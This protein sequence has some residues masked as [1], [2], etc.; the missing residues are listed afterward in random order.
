MAWR[1]GKNVIKADTV[2]VLKLQPTQTV[3]CMVIVPLYRSMHLSFEKLK[4]NLFSQ[5]KQP[6]Y[7]A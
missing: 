3:A 1:T 5:L 4:D 6:Y 7:K 2:S